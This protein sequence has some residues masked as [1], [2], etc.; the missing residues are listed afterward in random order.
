MTALVTTEELADRLPF[1]MDADEVRE[2]A[3]A[4]EDLSDDARHYGKE[5]WSEPD[6]APRQVKN[7]ILRA[8]VRHMKNFDGYTQSRAGDEAVSWTD[9]GEDAG[10]AYFTERE[11]KMLRA[12]AGNVRSGFHSVGMVAYGSTRLR[13]RALDGLVRDEGSSEPIQMFNDESPW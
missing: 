4:L 2:A 10:S 11:I 9:R 6:K 8:A 3:G 1:T 5:V 7:L 12:M 13:P